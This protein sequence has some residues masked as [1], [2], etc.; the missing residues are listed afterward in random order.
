[1]AYLSRGRTSGYFDAINTLRA[2]D[3][4]VCRLLVDVLL[5]EKD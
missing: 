2:L 5:Q 4:K 3:S 1:M